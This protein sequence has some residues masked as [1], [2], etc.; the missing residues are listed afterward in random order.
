MIE[1]RCLFLQQNVIE[2]VEGL[3]SL[4]NLVTLNLSE[5]RITHLECLSA[6]PSLQTLNVSKNLLASAAA[7]EHLSSCAS[8]VILDISDN[9]LSGSAEAN[10]P[11]VE[12]VDGV[13]STGCNAQLGTIHSVAVS[14]IREPVGDVV[15]VL[16]SIPKLSTLYLKGNPLVKETR[17]Y[18]KVMLS[19]M[20]RLG[21][22]DDRP[23]F[24]LERVAT[25]A[26]A[27]GGQEAELQ[28]ILDM[29]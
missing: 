16:Q 29:L 21:Y 15:R 5:N 13:R 27:V 18:R 28:V 24:P 4:Q 23:V 14:P 8:L 25:D 9:Q 2:R 11:G 12:N 6:L 1:L 17:H 3:E 26:W 22:L 10:H 19:L 7:V 20:P